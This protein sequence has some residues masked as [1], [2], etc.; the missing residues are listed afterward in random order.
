[1]VPSA[2]Q[3]AVSIQRSTG[4]SSMNFRRNALTLAFAV[5]SLGT[6]GALA[7]GTNGH[8]QA[9]Y[10]NDTRISGGAAPTL[11]PGQ[12]A[13]MEGDARSGAATSLGL[14]TGTANDTSAGHAQT[15]FDSDT[16]IMGQVPDTLPPDERRSGQ[17]MQQDR[18][19][20]G[21]TGSATRGPQSPVDE[22]T[23]SMD[24]APESLP[25]DA[26]APA[27]TVDAGTVGRAASPRFDNDVKAQGERVPNTPSTAR[28]A[29]RP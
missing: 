10:D 4:D 27:G 21:Q 3:R 15:G 19:L 8:A 11:A 23:R 12:G 28:P 14:D 29:T 20:A 26:A 24:R 17:P 7:G 1:M 6:A 2:Q 22:D 13:G 9:G 25:S 18:D 5:A 16:R